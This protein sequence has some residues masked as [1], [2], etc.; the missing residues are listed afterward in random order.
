MEKFKHWLLSKCYSY[1]TIKTYTNALKSFLVF[2]NEKT[3][4]EITEDVIL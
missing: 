4:A 1:S 3:V 2:F